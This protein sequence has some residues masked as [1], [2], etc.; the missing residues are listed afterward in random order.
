MSKSATNHILYLPLAGIALVVVNAAL[1]MAAQNGQVAPVDNMAL[2]GSFVVLTTCSLLWAAFVFGLHPLVAG[3][4]YA[5]GAAV[6]YM[7]VRLQA[8]LPAIEIATAGAT[9]SADLVLGKH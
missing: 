8:D 1:Y 9:C 6:A 3:A 4:S 2:W 5:A 7:N